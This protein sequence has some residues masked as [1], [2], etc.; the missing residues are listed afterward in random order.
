ME[1]EKRRE[2]T[3]WARPH[4]GKAG[5]DRKE[6]KKRKKKKKGEVSRIH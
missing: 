4:G 6:K 2:E 1:V 5:P 3:G